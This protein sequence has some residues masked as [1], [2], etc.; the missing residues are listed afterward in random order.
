[1]VEDLVEMDEGDLE[2]LE[3]HELGERY[4]ALLEAWNADPGT[5]RLPGGETMVEVRARA[6]A[7]LARIAAAAGEGERVAVVTHQLLISAVL[8]AIVGEP[9]STW[10]SRSHRNTSWSEVR[11]GSPPELRGFRLTPHLPPV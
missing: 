6:L 9:A 11:W 7:A 10:R 1:V 2:G 8:T 5:V 3:A 4:G